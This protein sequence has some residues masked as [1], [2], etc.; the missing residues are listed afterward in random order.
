MPGSG[1]NHTPKEVA[2]SMPWEKLC[3]HVTQLYF[4]GS[5]SPPA[6]WQFPTLSGRSPG[7]HWTLALATLPNSAKKVASDT[8]W[9]KPWH[10]LGSISNSHYPA[11][12]LASESLQGNP[13]SV[14]ASDSAL[15][16][17]PP[18]K[19]SLHRDAPTKGHAFR[20]VKV[21]ISPNIIETDTEDQT[22]WGN[23]RIYSKI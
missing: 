11:K 14:L 7:L 22:K 4:T 9:E 2:L 16:A 10:P 3:L 15:P 21:T 13:L 1:F 17:N 18:G 19:H 23:K 6:E 12:M 8:S 5:S 20:P